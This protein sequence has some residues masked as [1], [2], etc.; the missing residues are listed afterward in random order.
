M[1]NQKQKP[2]IEKLETNIATREY[3]DNISY[4]WDQTTLEWKIYK[5]SELV[6]YGGDLNRVIAIYA[7]GRE[8]SCRERIQH[9]ILKYIEAVIPGSIHDLWFRVYK[10]ENEEAVKLLTKLLKAGITVEAIKTENESDFHPVCVF[11]NNTID[12]ESIV[13]AI[14]EEH[15]QTHRGESVIAVK[16]R[17][18]KWLCDCWW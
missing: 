10:L 6:D 17:V 9:C 3:W 5:L 14:E 18:K 15:L 1:Y 11:H 13:A 4:E 7:N 12:G 8:R 2:C 16:N